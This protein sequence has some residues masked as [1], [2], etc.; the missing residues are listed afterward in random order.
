MILQ[1]KSDDPKLA[2]LLCTYNGEQF[3]AEQ[4]ES[5]A[6]QTHGNWFLLASDDNSS[7]ATP[8]ILRAFQGSCPPGQVELVQGPAEGFVQNFMSVTSKAEGRANY[9]AWADQD[10]IWHADKLE[11]A[12]NWL[13]T[14]PA[15]VPA[16]YCARTLLVSADNQ[17]LAPSMLF[18]K[19]TSFANALMQN[20]GGGNT[21]VFNQAACKILAQTS[22]SMPVVSHDWW[23]YIIITGVG[24]RVHYDREPCL[25]YR[26]HGQNLVG[27]NISW[28]ARLIRCKLLFEGRFRQWNEINIRALLQHQQRLTEQNRITLQHLIQIRQLPLL[29][30]LRL[31]KR[32]GLY[33][34]TALGNL[35]LIFATIFGKL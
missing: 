18:G 7:D 34:Q 14:L 8:D 28:R 11:R 21:M 31:L 12:V 20:I 30:R 10:D 5:F 25:R 27:G 24:G 26:Q 32:S 17:P 15:D 2:I 23:A 33:R 13:N 6:A 19:K 3:L 35:G 22:S 1:E 9:Y 16:L 4:L 29:Q